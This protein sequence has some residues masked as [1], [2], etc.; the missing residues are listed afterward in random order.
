M[1]GAVTVAC[2]LALTACE[3]PQP[4]R[5]PQTAPRTG[6][7][8]ETADTAEPTGAPADRA[9]EAERFAPQV[10]LADLDSYGPMAADEFVDSA[11]LRWAHD[12]GCGDD[13]VAADVDQ[14][15]LAAGKYLH[16]GKGGPPGCA[17]GGRNY[18]SNENTRPRSSAELGAEGFYLKGPDEQRHGTG[19][20]APV[21]WQYYDGAYVYWFFYPYN[22][23]PS[24]PV[25]VPPAPITAVDAFDHEGDW[26]RIAVRTDDDGQAVGVTL[27]GHGNSCYVRD[28][29][30]DW[31]DGHPVVFSA[32]GTHASYPD[33]GV[34]RYGIDIATEG[35]RWET[36]HA[37]RPVADEPWYG[38][39][40]G[41]GSVGS[42][43]PDATHRTGPAGPQPDRLPTDAW[44]EHHCSEADQLPSAMRGEWKSPQPADQPTSEKTY[45]VRLTLTGGAVDTDV[46]TVAYPGLDCGGKLTLLE[47]EPNKAK[48]R[49]TITDDPGEVSCTP[50]G[51]VD[52]TLDGDVLNMTYT[53]DDGDQSMTARLTRQR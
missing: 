18:A 33:S 20:S 51:T 45:Y 15:M 24:I 47:V 27:W 9:S 21:Y 7:P 41:W 28:D 49:E 35:T 6:S 11:E 2:V 42:P 29:Q 14:E 39:G 16:Q 46:A 25:G 31:A 4:T 26:E 43:G 40:G 19:T 53:R 44:T 5:P 38:Y 36:W 50:T 37:V 8:A 22:D 48:L 3:D 12:N 32:R 1:A 10:W 17:H 23:A 30:L 52:L 34:H 13:R